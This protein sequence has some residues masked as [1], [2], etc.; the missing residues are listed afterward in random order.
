[1][2][3]S[4]NDAH[5]PFNKLDDGLRY[6]HQF[7]YTAI[8]SSCSSIDVSCKSESVVVVTACTLRN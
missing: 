7:L 6:E 4:M 8:A 3:A 1:M 5:L 2:I